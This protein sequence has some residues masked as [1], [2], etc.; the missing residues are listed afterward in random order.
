MKEYL[1]SLIILILLILF[2]LFFKK[3]EFFYDSYPIV[4][5]D[6]ND[7]SLHLTLSNCDTVCKPEHPNDSRFLDTHCNKEKHENICNNRLPIDKNTILSE[8]NKCKFEPHQLQHTPPP[9]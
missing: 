1:I 7:D 6:A 2:I 8:Q 9:Y 4:V 3:K 5:S